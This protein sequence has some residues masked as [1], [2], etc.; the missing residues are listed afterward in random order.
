MVGVPVHSKHQDARKAFQYQYSVASAWWQRW[1][2][3]YAKTYTGAPMPM[4]PHLM[5]EAPKLDQP[6]MMAPLEIGRP[7]CVVTA[8]D[9][10]ASMR[11]MPTPRSD[12]ALRED[13]HQP[14]ST[15][16]SSDA[17]RSSAVKV[18]EPKVR[19]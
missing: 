4:P 13:T 1:Y 18:G 2:Q 14:R 10:G 5:D 12:I 17:A 6:S 19:F 16:T 7:A 3:W 9:D 15:N 8:S 11:T